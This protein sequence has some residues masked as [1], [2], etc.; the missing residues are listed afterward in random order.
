[1]FFLRFTLRFVCCA[2][3]CKLKT[4][5][6]WGIISIS[7]HGCKK[8]VLFH[9]WTFVYPNAPAQPVSACQ[10]VSAPSA[11][12]HLA[13][14]QLDSTVLLL[15]SLGNIGAYLPKYIPAERVEQNRVCA[16]FV[17]TRIGREGVWS[18][19]ERTTCFRLTRFSKTV[20]E[21]IRLGKF[22]F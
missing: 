12:H 10:T 11:G 6:M 9:T 8:S 5:K 18:L 17:M 15:Q 21:S 1:M 19:R 14:H 22:C 13:L 20:I 2:E 7:G 3:Q 16:D 4:I